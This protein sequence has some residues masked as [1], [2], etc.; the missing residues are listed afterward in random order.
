MME[1]RTAL[2]RLALTVACALLVVVV[3]NAIAGRLLDAHTTNKGYFLIHEKWRLLEDEATKPVDWL[4]LGD[5]SCNQGL[6]PAALTER[7]GGTALNLCT[8]ADL[9]VVNDAW[10]LDRYIE[11]FGPPKRVV[12]EHVYDVWHRRL[13]ADLKPEILAEVPQPWG[14]WRDREPKLRLSRAQ[15]WSLGLARYV[16]LY[17]ESATL[18]SWLREP[19]RFGRTFALDAS[20]FMAHERSDVRQ[21]KQDTRNHLRFLKGRKF[22]ISRENQR[23][24]D[25]IAALSD[26]HG[27]DVF[28]V[29]TSPVYEELAKSEDYKRYTGDIVRTLEN[30]AR[31]HSR[32]HVVLK[33]PV[34]FPARDMENA[35][36]LTAKAAKRYTQR[37][38]AEIEELTAPTPPVRAI[39]RGPKAHWFAYYDK[40]QF[41]P[42][43]RYVLGMQVDFEDRNPKPD[44][45]VRV[46]MVDLQ[47]GDRWIELGESRAW[48]WQQGCMLQWIP[49]TDAQVLWNDREG[50]RFVTRILDV[51][52]RETRTLPLPVYA[53]APDGKSAVSADFA[54]VH[55]QRPGYGYVGLPDAHAEEDAP[56]TSGVWWMD[57]ATGEHRLVFS[58]ADA[59]KVGA[60]SAD[61]TGA[62]HALYHLLY[63]P[64]GKR[65][66]MVHRWAK[67][68]GERFSSRLL[69][70][71]P[72]GG[73]PR[74]V[75]PGRYVSHFWWRD[76]EHITAWAWHDSAGAQFYAFP[77][78]GGPPELIAPEAMR[79]D[80]HVSYLPGNRF[81]LNDTYPDV[82]LRQHPYLYDLV[83]KRRIP[84]GHFV[85]NTTRGGLDLRCD[86]HPR[87]SRDGG[88]V[89]IDSTHEGQR[90]MYLID[91]RALTGA[92]PAVAAGQ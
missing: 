27:F 80:G 2:R 72:Q 14:F 32:V 11:R 3:A 23:A 12:V 63:S 62:K 55:D 84:L 15:K 33:R 71:D 19:S 13:G 78:R 43:G 65:V 53:V 34:P 75:H 56:A 69:T 46:G 83:E 47:D 92:K 81:I 58:T 1:R 4:L 36:H 82:H 7:L 90:Q 59:L 22:A 42:T 41:D 77:E 86:T 54:R 51:K 52:T 9:L 57:L 39:T 31:G 88:S 29:A 37:V 44:D 50:D 30:H 35:D 70:I 18:Q 10:M 6:D 5:S 74:V 60:P 24:L 21:V 28:L 45:V 79:E 73:E 26:E 48:N 89:V 67:R 49:G 87:F 91:V 38:A 20:G 8:V 40:L 76:P 64:D 68:G 17:S 16:P 61:W 66:A 85:S 25:R